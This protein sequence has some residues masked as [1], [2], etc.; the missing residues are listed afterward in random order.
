M[1]FSFDNR[2]SF[3]F[4]KGLLICSRLFIYRCKFLKSKPDMLQHFN[5]INLAKKPEHICAKPE[6]ICAKPEHICAKPEHICAKPEHIC[7]KPEH[8][9]AKPKHI[10]AKRNVN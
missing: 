1:L 7:A 4:K 5:L 2:G 6:H 8:I 3:F 10:C 9:C